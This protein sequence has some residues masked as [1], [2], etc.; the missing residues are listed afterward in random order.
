MRV[1]NFLDIESDMDIVFAV[2]I[3]FSFDGNNFE[4]LYFP[5]VISK[6]RLVLFQII[7]AN[8]IVYLMER[9]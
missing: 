7:N 9:S 4:V 6:V 5:I 2:K 3:E 8:W 1:A